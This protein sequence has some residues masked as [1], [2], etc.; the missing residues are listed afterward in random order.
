MRRFPLSLFRSMRV[1]GA[2]LALFA[3]ALGVTE[4]VRASGGAPKQHVFT[5]SIVGTS[6][7]HG[8]FMERGGRGGLGLFAG[9]VNNLRAARKADAGAVILLDAGDTFQGGVESNLS[10]GAVVV[11][12]YTHSVTPRW[13]S[14][15][16]SSISDRPID[17]ARDKIRTLTR[18]GR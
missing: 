10:E 17:L 13:L 7:L 8:Y 6:D 1:A 11:D 18:A 9:Y 5:L 4:R 12:A 14:A 16:T 3:L 15:I 2:L